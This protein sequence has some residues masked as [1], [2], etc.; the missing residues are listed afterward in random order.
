MKEQGKTLELDE[1]ENIKGW[2]DVISGLKTQFP[3]QFEKA[4]GGKI[5]EPNPLPKGDP[6]KPEPQSLAEA[7]KAQYETN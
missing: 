7:L 1:N 6:G 4:G 3:T 2:D 5:V